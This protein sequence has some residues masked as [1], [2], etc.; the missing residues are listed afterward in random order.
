[1]TARSASFPKTERLR[2]TNE[3]RAIFKNAPSVRENGIVLYFAGNHS[4]ARS[5]LGVVVSRRV[6]KRAVDR[7]RAKRTI[8]EFFRLRKAGFRAN[9]DLVVRVIDGGK[10]F[11]N[12]NLEKTLPRLFQRADIFHEE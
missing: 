2:Q 3:F 8:R 12:S 11:E 7:N 1:M 10:L 5:R 4:R 6:F 9:F